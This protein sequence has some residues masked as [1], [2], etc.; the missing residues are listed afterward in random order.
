MF[1]IACVLLGTVVVRSLRFIAQGEEILDC[2][3]QHFLENDKKTRR[4]LLEKKY[5]FKCQCV[6]CTF[7]WPTILPN[8]QFD[9]K[10][11]KCS[12]TCRKNRVI[13]ECITCGSKTEISKLYGLLQDSI[14]KRLT[15]LTRMYDGNYADALPLLLEHARCIDKILLEPSLEAIKTQQSII[16]CL[17]AMSTTSV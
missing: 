2:Y 13:A 1:K 5:Y 15:A 17:N 11:K 4:E 9:F 12:Q 10:C 7:D 8:D 3:G 6:A 16:Q 14:K